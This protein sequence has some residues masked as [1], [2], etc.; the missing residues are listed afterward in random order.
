MFSCDA[1]KAVEMAHDA[2]GVYLCSLEDDKDLIPEPSPPER[3]QTHPGQSIALVDVDTLEYRQKYGSR[4]VKKTLSIPARRN[5][6]AAKQHLNPPTTEV[7]RMRGDSTSRLHLSWLCSNIAIMLSTGL[8][9]FVRQEW[10]APATPT[11]ISNL[12]LHLWV[13]RTPFGEAVRKAIRF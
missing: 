10:A 12:P 8:L 2:L 6:M 3:I 13:F 1:A 5:D 9:Q 4:S 7:T 11:C